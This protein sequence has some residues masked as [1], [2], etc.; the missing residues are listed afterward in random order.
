[1]SINDETVKHLAKL[2][3]LKVGKDNP[4]LTQQL[5][6][7]FNLVEQVNEA[8]TENL[9]PMSHP[10]DLS[11]PLRDDIISEKNDR[12]NLMHNAPET[13]EGF[14]LVPKVID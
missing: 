2:A 11:Q 3:K 7:I 14:F 10:L 1:M 9:S 6:N 12:N 13:H 8:D 4:N 5:N